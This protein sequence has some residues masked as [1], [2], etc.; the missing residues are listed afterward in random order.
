MDISNLELGQKIYT[1]DLK[2]DDYSFL[3]S[4]NTVICQVK[5]SRASLMPEIEEPETDS[6]E[7]DESKEAAKDTKAEENKETPK[8]NENKNSDQK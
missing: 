5:T 2:H 4:E 6:A 3:H 8:E 7:T 1:V